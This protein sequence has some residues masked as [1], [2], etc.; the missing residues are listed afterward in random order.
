MRG[1]EGG[2]RRGSHDGPAI[3]CTGTA[4][5]WQEGQLASITVGVV[6]LGGQE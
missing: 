3:P 1:I 4:Q 5:A 6:V 2:T